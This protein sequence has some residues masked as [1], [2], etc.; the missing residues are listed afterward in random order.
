MFEYT[1]VAT[2]YDGPRTRVVRG[3][4][5][6][7]GT[8]IVKQLKSAYPTPSELA[9]LEREH[10]LLAEL[11]GQG[12]CRT[13]GYDEREARL[14]LDDNGAVA[15]SVLLARRRFTAAE[16]LTVARNAAVCLAGVHA[17]GVLHRDVNPSNM[18]VD[19]ETLT[20][21]LIDFD[22]ASPV[23][24]RRARA[25]PLATMEGTPAYVSPEQTGRM[26]RAVDARSDLYSL[27][28]TLFELFSG[29][30]P[31]ESQD[32][33]GL[34]H[35]HLAQA[36]P[37]LDPRMEGL[38]PATAELVDT[39]MRKRPGDRYQSAAGVVADLERLLTE[40]RGGAVAVLSG[41]SI[42]DK[43]ELP[44]ELHG[45]EGDVAALVEDF[46]RVR[47]GGCS[48]AFVSGEAGIGKTSLVHELY[49]PVTLA[50]ARLVEGKFDQFS[51]DTPYSAIGQVLGSLAN[52][53]LGGTP[54]AVAAT[55]RRLLQATHPNT[56][57][58]LELAPSLSL[59]IGPQPPVQELPPAEGARRLQETM[60][61][62]MAALASEDSPLVLFLDDLQ[63]ADLPSLK[64]LESLFRH[65]DLAY[66]ML[67]A[68]WRSEEVG[69]EHAVRPTVQSLRDSGVPVRDIALGPLAQEDMAAIISVA[70][71]RSVDEL[72]P[73]VTALFEKTGG[74][75]FFL[76]RLV[77]RAWSSGA[78]RFDAE[79]L[80]WRWDAARISELAPAANVIGLLRSELRHQSDE[81]RL[82][83]SAGALLADAFATDALEIATG[84]PTEAIV[85][86]M[87]SAVA[88]RFVHPLDD[89]WWTG[90]AGSDRPFRFAF[91]HDR[92]QQAAREL[93]TEDQLAALHLRMAR[94]LRDAPAVQ[95]HP[96]EVAEHYAAA[97]RLVTDPDERRVVVRIAMQAGER[98]LRAAAFGPA[99]G[100]LETALELVPTDVWETERDVA[101][102]LVTLAARAGWL[103]GDYAALERHVQ[104]LRDR[105]VSALDRILAEEVMVSAT[106]A[107]GELNLALDQALD[108]LAA[109]GTVMPRHPSPDEV[110][111][112]VGATIGLLAEHDLTELI[113]RT[114][115]E[116]EARE[117]AE[118]R[119]LIHITAAAY[120]S[121][122]NL[123]PLIACDLVQ[124][125]VRKG[126][127]KESAYGFAVYALTLCAGWMLEMGTRMGQVALEL[128]DTYP[129][130]LLRGMT[131]HVVDN[132][133]RLW[134]EPLA[135]IYADNPD[136]VRMLM[137]AGDLELA[138]WSLHQRTLYGLW[139]GVPLR[140]FQD[141]VDTVLSAL[142]LHDHQ[143]AIV[144]TMPVRLLVGNLRGEAPE[145]TRLD[146][147][148]YDASAILR[149]LRAINFR[150]GG[151][152]LSIARM[153]N[154]LYFGDHAGAA[155]VAED[156]IE[157][158]DGAVAIWYQV[159]WRAYAA[160]VLLDQSDD[161]DATLERV[162][163]WRDA[164]AAAAEH[165]SANGAHLLALYDAEVALA[166]GQL[167]DAITHWDRAITLASEAN[168]PQDEGLINERVGRFHLRRGARRIARAYLLDAR[169][170]W[171]RWGA[172]AKVEQLDAEFEALLAPVLRASMQT[173]ISPTLTTGS[174]SYT[175][176]LESVL[177]AAGAIAQETD[178]ERLMS[179][180]LDV[181][182]ENV[183]AR[184]GT[185]M[186]VHRGDLWVEALAHVG[187]PVRLTGGTPLDQHEELHEPII[188]RVFRRGVAEVH[189]D[190]FGG[191][192]P[193]SVLCMPVAHQ[194]RVLGVL[195]FEN[196]LSSGAFT[197][198]RLRVLEALA[199]QLAVAVRNA[200]LQ[201]AQERFVPRQF[202]A[203][204]D[205]EDI[206]D[207]QVGD[208]RLKEVTVFFSDVWGFTPL[209]EQ[210]TA[211]EALDLVNRYLSFAEPAI[212]GVG[213]FIDTYLGDGIMALFDQP[214]A[215][216]QLAVTAAVAVH[217]ALDRF[218]EARRARGQR[219]IRT[220]IG[221]NTGVVT[222]ATIGGERSLKCGV[223]GDAVN[224]ASRVEGLTRRCRARVLISGETHSRLT[225]LQDLYLRTAG[226]V[227]VR[228]RSKPLTLYEVLAAEP[229][230]LLLE[231]LA[232]LD[233]YEDAIT[234]Y[235]SGDPAR[236]VRGFANCLRQTPDDVQV[237]HFLEAAQGLLRNGVPEHWDG[238]EDIR[239]KR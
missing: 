107:R 98:A 199:A 183:G 218:N 212:T 90:A 177:K 86:A 41:R 210:L 43:L 3:K 9:R 139:C 27:G 159:T 22:L 189:D 29:S 124:R 239:T 134:S 4:R 109:A 162:V 26:N 127:S 213:G 178:L 25:Q 180:G 203:S 44:Q 224:L 112:A 130:R 135:Q 143:A 160:L 235:F 50:G 172:T 104:T 11:D 158:Q 100:F 52:E 55:R 79:S 150:A 97:A 19:P 1:E 30:L 18:I 165:N 47:G 72:E 110:M 103:V 85:R 12:V 179:R 152:T 141:E 230:A 94:G 33:V 187:K 116:D 208:H 214:D 80:S 39:L 76:H 219:E 193:R 168:F 23:P 102:Q 184:Q 38:P 167:L 209:V 53:V 20:T 51:R 148:D 7:G 108:V 155:E 121:E 198:A 221:L 190:V 146:R 129:D 122:P 216:A 35:A 234:A 75:P 225:D 154:R 73:L 36:P 233:E 215:N 63:W 68:S 163:P 196:D 156:V 145:A 220:G 83:L 74:N 92:V 15:L 181:L 173:T 54:E 192:T 88:G 229:P 82:C 126:A 40:A 125:T 81:V 171:Q 24:H 42:T 111:A 217:R 89:N 114:C 185:L 34:A 120:L 138:G 211:A 195:F 5:A 136:V 223:V 13:F 115:P 231:R 87:A 49:K 222:M 202:L 206:V 95:A 174:G 8:L 6:E 157:L 137:D 166:R 201:A 128:L 56:A 164:L 106:A 67:I 59:L 131:R 66:L 101:W 169:Y 119:L 123:L 45:R 142:R 2:L 151:L 140:E 161:L 226:R 175:L 186:L 188:R 153:T 207:V 37:P 91:V 14:L 113:A 147:E 32:L 77:E 118:R 78:I 65:P 133:S 182:V 117:L 237:Q 17:R 31:F 176:D 84:L 99:Q 60:R 16:A 61:R 194:G 205:R 46:E 10:G 191:P 70:M 144:C 170:A 105:S 93:L 96:F 71:R 69:T 149:E 48:V 64:V 228:G 132:F 21:W 232:T 62:A 200:R 204:L 236:A 57:L 238:I 197:P 28:V 227:R 58:L